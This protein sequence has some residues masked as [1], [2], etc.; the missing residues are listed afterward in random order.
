MDSA[1]ACPT[2]PAGLLPDLRSSVRRSGRIAS[3]LSLASITFQSGVALLFPLGWT[4]I[5]F[6]STKSKDKSSHS[7]PSSPVATSALQA[8]GR[9][10]RSRW[11][12]FQ[13]D[14][15]PA[16]VLREVSRSLDG[17]GRDASDSVQGHRDEITTAFLARPS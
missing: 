17:R 3:P 6:V 8:K 15:N 5:S 12:R 14:I 10:L 1:G 2:L 7:A 16:R 9:H 13:A 4:S 11:I